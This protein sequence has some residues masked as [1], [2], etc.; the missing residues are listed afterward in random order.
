MSKSIVLKRN[1]NDDAKYNQLKS[2]NPVRMLTY[3]NS[4][5]FGTSKM[6]LGNVDYVL[7]TGGHGNFMASRPTQFNDA[8]IDDTRRWMKGVNG[9]AKAMILDTC[10]SSALCEDFIRFVPTGGAVV[11]AHGSGE[12]WAGAFNTDNG[13]KTVGEVL[14]G[15]VDASFELTGAPSIALMLNKPHQRNLFTCNSGATRGQ[16]LAMKGMFGMD[17]DTAVE[18]KELDIY[19]S[20]KGIMVTPMTRDQLKSYLKAVLPM[21]V[22]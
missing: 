22:M 13:T 20:H 3:N 4:A 12:G 21:K 15:I 7:F 6:D 14:C 16:T 2:L 18:L 9:T 1:N 10:F 11:C 17:H 5:N 19:L 8:S